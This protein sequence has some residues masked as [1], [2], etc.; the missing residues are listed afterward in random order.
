[1]NQ[2]SCHHFRGTPL[3]KRSWRL[4]YDD[5]LGFTLLE[6]MVSLLI[7]FAI[8]A[9]LLPIFMSWRLNTINN[10]IKTGAIAISQQILDELRQDNS[11]SS[12]DDS[13]TALTVKPSGESIAVIDYGGRTYNASL[14]YCAEAVYCDTNTRH[15]TLEVSYNNDTIYTIKTV[16]TSFD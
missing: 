9:G 2:T 16:Y 3:D 11:V 6:A 4:I 7:L 1:M 14:T 10:S 15:V 5:G 8:M 13:N 12:W